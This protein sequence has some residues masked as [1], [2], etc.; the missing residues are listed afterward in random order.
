LKKGGHLPHRFIKS[1]LAVSLALFMAACK[2]KEPP[3]VIEE[4]PA[5][6]APAE[7]DTSAHLAEEP[8][9]KK[10]GEENKAPQ[11]SAAAQEAGFSDHGPFVVQVSVF[12]GKRQA[13]GL[14]EKLA[15]QGYP[16]YVA[17]VEN[18]TP[19]LSG[20][21]HRVRIGRFARIADAKSFGQ[22]T[23]KPMGYDFW[24]D[25]KKNDKVGAGEGAVSAAPRSGPSKA[26]IEDVP[27][28]APTVPSEPAPPAATGES[29]GTPKSDE[30]PAPKGDAWGTPKTEEPAAPAS[31]KSKAEPAAPAGDAW[32]T[33]KTEEPAAPKGD[34]WGTPKDGQPAATSTTGGK[35]KSD[36]AP[37]GKRAPGD[38]GKVNLDE[39]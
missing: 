4:V 3:A 28:P 17:V 34:S 27:P 32:G 29:W 7:T 11:H 1:F 21:W 5:A 37:A 33:P 31:N 12:K 15:A 38:T 26:V 14:V 23:L 10:V 22:N 35:K 18:P 6:A 16:A 36:S 20:T 39:W 13:S 2:K 25:N 24:V 8:N 30:P 19:E 9:L